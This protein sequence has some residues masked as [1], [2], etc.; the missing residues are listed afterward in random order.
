MEEMRPAALALKMLFQNS[1]FCTKK[2]DRWAPALA[3]AAPVLSPP[4]HLPGQRVA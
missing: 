3:A 2:M 1:L 4:P